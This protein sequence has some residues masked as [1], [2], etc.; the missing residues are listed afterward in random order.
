MEYT[1]E[2]LTDMSAADIRILA[3]GL[4]IE[5]TTKT[6]TIDR[7]IQYQSNK[8]DTGVIV[9]DTGVNSPETVNNPGVN[10]TNPETNPSVSLK[11]TSV[12][13]NAKNDTSVCT[14]GCPMP[15]PKTYWSKIGVPVGNDG[16]KIRYRLN[17]TRIN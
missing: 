9:N 13:P 11:T 5:Y 4:K 17:G 6:P 1:K 3:E 10:S 2:E 12:N 8:T 7:I 16:D 15:P 14:N